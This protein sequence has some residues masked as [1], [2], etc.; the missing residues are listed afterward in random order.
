V[1]YIAVERTKWSGLKKIKY[2]ENVPV[3]HD[4][5]DWVLWDD[6]TKKSQALQQQSSDTIKLSVNVIQSISDN[7]QP[8]ISQSKL[9]LQPKLINAVSDEVTNKS[10][11]LVVQI[12]LNPSNVKYITSSIA[13]EYQGQKYYGWITYDNSVLKRQGQE[14]LSGD[15]IQDFGFNF[16]GK[17]YYRQD[18]YWDTAGISL[19]FVDGNPVAA[20]FA[21]N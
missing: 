14:W 2:W 21:F 10:Q 19:G 18:F 17:T 7:V 4:D 16:L 8:F 1:E 13:V 9:V 12:D 20:L 15:K 11:D 5:P 6:Y 3:Y